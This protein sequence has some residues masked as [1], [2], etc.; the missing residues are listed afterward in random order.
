[1]LPH[2]GT[3]EKH[4]QESAVGSIKSAAVMAIIPL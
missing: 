1:M 4:K 2:I 3:A